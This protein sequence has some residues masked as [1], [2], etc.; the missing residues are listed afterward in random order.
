MNP[1]EASQR[2]VW[3][4][5]GLVLLPDICAWR[6]PPREDRGFFDERFVATD[7][8]RH[9]LAKLWTRAH[10]LHE[11]DAADPYELVGVLGENDVDQLLSRRRDIAATPALVR[12]IVRAH[13]DDPA[14]LS[15]GDEASAQVE[16]VVLRD[17]VK[18]LRRLSAFLDL[19]TRSPAELD[20]LVRRT[21]QEAREAI[22][23]Q[24]SAAPS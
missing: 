1:G 14:R 4:F 10:V 11:P 17:S 3:S 20:A 15:G 6:Y 18:R 24:A 5:L 13:R 23:G 7:L 16:R 2:G 12:A 8:T 21:R 22:V 9:T 19:D